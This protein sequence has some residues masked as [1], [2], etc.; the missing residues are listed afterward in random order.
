M[1]KNIFLNSKKNE[2]KMPPDR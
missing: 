1:S 2:T